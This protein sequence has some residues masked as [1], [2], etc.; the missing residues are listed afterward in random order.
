[1]TDDVKKLE[2]ATTMLGFSVYRGALTARYEDGIVK[3]AIGGED[4]IALEPVD[5]TK[6]AILLFKTAN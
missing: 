4:I 3:I 5:A 1:M 2:K 6:L